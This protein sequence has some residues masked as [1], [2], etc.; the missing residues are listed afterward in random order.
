MK[1]HAYPEMY[2]NRAQTVLGTA[3]DYAIIDC[4]VKGED[5]SKIFSISR[6]ATRMENGET[7]CILGRSGV[8]L[9]QDILLDATGKAYQIEPRNSFHRSPEYWIG[10]AI[11]YYQ[12]VSD[13][14]YREILGTLSYDELMSMYETLHE[15]DITKFAEVADEVI[16]RRNLETNLR[17]IRTNYGCTQAELARRSGVSLRSI[18]MYEQRNKNINKAGAETVYRLSKVLGCRMEDLIER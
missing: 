8:E 9:A 3:F 17:Y 7:A 4:K 18:Q 16:R 12:W 11:A 1:I 14:R 13:R 2:L 5:F 6:I 15:A 10:W